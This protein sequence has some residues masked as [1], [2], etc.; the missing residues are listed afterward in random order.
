MIIGILGVPVKRGAGLHYVWR[1]GGTRSYFGSRD[2]ERA[3]AKA[4]ELAQASGAGRRRAEQRRRATRGEIV[5]V[6]SRSPA[7]APC[8]Q[9]WRR[10]AS[11]IC[12]RHCG[13]PRF[14]SKHAYA[15]P[16]GGS[17]AEEAQATLPQ[18]ACRGRLHQIAAHELSS[19][20]R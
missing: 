5:I 15:P 19:L 10:P 1:E 14:Q 18:A 13:P 16:P 9:S 6:A 12:R 3:R 2:A 4:S 8:S 7:I 11:K 17:A 20:R